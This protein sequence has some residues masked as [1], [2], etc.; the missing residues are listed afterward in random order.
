MKYLSFFLSLSAL[1][2]IASCA[3]PE[4]IPEPDNSID[5]RAH[6]IGNVNGSE[7]EFTENVDGKI[8]RAHV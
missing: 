3:K 6:F 1:V 7:I 8:G 2:L 4:I 5:Y